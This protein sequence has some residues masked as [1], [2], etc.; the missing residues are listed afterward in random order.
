MSEPVD[1][2]TFIKILMEDLGTEAEFKGKKILVEDL[3]K[4]SDE[5]LEDIEF[6]DAG[7]KE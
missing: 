3:D 4:L 6:L 1:M 2:R 7:L 5:E